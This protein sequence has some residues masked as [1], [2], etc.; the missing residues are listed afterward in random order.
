MLHPEGQAQK[1]PQCRVLL[2]TEPTNGVPSHPHLK[3]GPE[4]EWRFPSHT[5]SE[6][7]SRNEFLDSLPSDL[8]SVWRMDSRV[9]EDG[10]AVESAYTLQ[11]TDMVAHTS[12]PHTEKMR[13]AA[14]AV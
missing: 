2:M 1:Q 9:W 12:N 4:W 14:R 7:E 10:M 8:C 13:L 6:W 3:C 11:Y 5:A